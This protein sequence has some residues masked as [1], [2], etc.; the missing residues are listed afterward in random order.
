MGEL[1][2][3]L[4]GNAKEA[5]G[6]V[7]GDDQMKNEGRAQQTVGNVKGVANDV[8][9]KVGSAVDDAKNNTDNRDST[10]D[11]NR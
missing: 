8:K 4:Q 3:K 2:D 7:S 5:A 10:N 9:D 1:K 6:A 11:P